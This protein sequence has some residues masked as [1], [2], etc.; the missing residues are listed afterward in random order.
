MGQW[1]SFYYEG[2]HGERY[3]AGGWHCGIIREIPIK[4]QHKNWM[5]IEIMVDHYSAEEDPKTHE[6][7]RRMVGHDKPWVF[8]ANVNELGDT[9]YHGPKLN[10]VVA[11]RKEEKAKDE[12]AA[13]KLRKGKLRARKA[14]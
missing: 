14:A 1:C 12:A 9:I 3:W 8:G 7:I 13:E 6:R 2:G 5:R 4:G 11:E 10:E